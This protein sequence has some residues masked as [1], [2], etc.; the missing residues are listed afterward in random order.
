[1]EK[2]GLDYGQLNEMLNGPKQIKLADVK[3]QLKK[4]AFDMVTFRD[5]P[6]KLWQITKGDDGQD[7]IVA[8]Y[9]SGETG[10]EKKEASA[11]SVASDKL[12]KNAT[13]FYKNTPITSLNFNEIGVKAEEIEN[14]K[15][16]LPKLLA[17]KK[18]HVASMLRSLDP[19]Y[20]A[21]IASLYPELY[22]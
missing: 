2:H 14:F 20:R 11:W 10:L 3:D 18:E 19:N 6:E 5:N 15:S 8:M 17:S 22:K 1:M 4:V 21:K 13:I 16:S 9:S 7:Y 12:N